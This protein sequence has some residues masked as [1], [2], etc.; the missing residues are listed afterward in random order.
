MIVAADIPASPPDSAMI[1]ARV[2]LY[3]VQPGS[4]NAQQRR[5]DGRDQES[6]AGTHEGL[7]KAMQAC[8]RVVAESQRET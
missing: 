2:P 4:R 6:D 3:H 8:S 1:K 7:Q 5:N